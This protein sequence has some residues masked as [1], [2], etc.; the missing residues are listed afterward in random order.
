MEFYKNIAPIIFINLSPLRKRV[1]KTIRDSLKID[2]GGWGVVGERGGRE[3]EGRVKSREKRVPQ[4][5]SRMPRRR[6]SL[7]ERRPI[8]PPFEQTSFREKNL[9][10][11]CFKYR[12][13]LSR[14]CGL[15]LLFVVS[16]G[17]AKKEEKNAQR[18]FID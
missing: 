6:T 15:R 1:A 11:L 3:F 9:E 5:V 16:D 12:L 17:F 14:C 18:I 13:L 2:L 10:E 7:C 8:L 4:T